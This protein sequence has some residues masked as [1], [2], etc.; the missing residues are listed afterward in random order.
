MNKH[1][2]IA[3]SILILA[4]VFLRFL[5]HPPNFTPIAALALFSGVI[6]RDRFPALAMPLCIMLVSDLFLGLHSTILFVYGAFALMVLMGRA[7]KS[8]VSVGYIA[9]GGITG[10][11]LFF[12]ITN[13]GVWLT[14]AMYP[15][16]WQGLVAAY[17]AAIP[18]LHNM[19]LGTLFYSAVF[20]GLFYLAE[21]WIPSMQEESGHLRA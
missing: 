7:L 19:I 12:I 5:P 17:I 21:R 2:I 1:R 13:F 20:F 14:S 18:F 16:T 4:A 3:I 15:L 9:G 6:F 8:R 10:A 11:M